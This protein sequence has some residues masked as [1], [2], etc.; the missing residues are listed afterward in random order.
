M[1]VTGEHVHYYCVST[2]FLCKLV[3]C[4]DTDYSFYIKPIQRKS[5]GTV[6]NGLTLVLN[7]TAEVFF[8]HFANK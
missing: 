4:L 1:Y 3:N 7:N 6:S 2:S 5:I 8:F